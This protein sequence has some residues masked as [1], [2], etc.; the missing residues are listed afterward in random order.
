MKGVNTAQKTRVLL[1][2]LSIAVPFFALAGFLCIG[3]ASWYSYDFAF[4]VS[5]AIGAIVLERGLFMQ[6]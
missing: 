1:L 4:L 6:E 5:I 2:G 3:L